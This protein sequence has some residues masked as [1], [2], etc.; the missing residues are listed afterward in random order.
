MSAKKNINHFNI[1]FV[2]IV[3]RC[4][5]QRKIKVAVFLFGVVLKL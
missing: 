1:Y 5:K 2:K 3:I 4:I